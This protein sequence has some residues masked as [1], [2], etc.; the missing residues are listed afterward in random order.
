M[1]DSKSTPK[2]ASTRLGR[3][4]LMVLLGGLLT[5]A[6]MICIAA[7]VGGTNAWSG[8]QDVLPVYALAMAITGVSCVWSVL[9]AVRALR[10]GESATLP[11]WVFNIATLPPALYGLAHWFILPHHILLQK[12]WMYEWGLTVLLPFFSLACITGTLIIRPLV[13]WLIR[14]RAAKGKPAWTRGQRIGRSVTFLCE[15]TLMIGLLILPM[16]LYINAML[17]PSRMV[18]KK[19]VL[20]SAPEIMRDAAE[21]ILR[22]ELNEMWRNARLRMYN[23]GRVSLARL[24]KRYVTIDTLVQQSVLTGAAEK[25]PKWANDLALEILMSTTQVTIYGQ[26]RY[27]EHLVA[28]SGTVEQQTAYIRYAMQTNMDL[29]NFIS[30]LKPHAKLVPVLLE[31]VRSQD[32]ARIQAFEKLSEHLPDDQAVAMLIELLKSG[33]EVFLQLMIVDRIPVKSERVR[34]YIFLY[35]L[36]QPDLALRRQALSIAE[37]EFS[38]YRSLYT[39]I[40]LVQKMLQLMSSTDISMRRGDGRI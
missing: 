10:S 23:E 36:E 40:E 15:Y 38:G 16:A 27:E 33:D 25:D 21:S 28:T 12:D 35:L 5:A 1:S 14:R 6:A 18:D 11:L 13:R 20:D 4:A 17:N 19:W 9:L 26:N 22:L 30:E 7:F 31:L 8:T 2:K 39:Q 29:Q 24:K 32:S 37:F 34:L 3:T